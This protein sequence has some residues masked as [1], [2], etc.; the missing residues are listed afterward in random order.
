MAALAC[1]TTMG[2][3]VNRAGISAMEDNADQSKELRVDRL[4]RQYG[5]RHD[6]HVD[7]QEENPSAREVRRCLILQSEKDRT[8]DEALD[9]ESTR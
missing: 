9:D 3:W 7:S 1:F 6:I 8:V 4:D 2:R 5:Q